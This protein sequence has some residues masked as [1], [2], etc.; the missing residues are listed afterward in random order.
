[1]WRSDLQA[2]VP[3][4]AELQGKFCQTSHYFFM[5]SNYILCTQEHRKVLFWDTCFIDSVYR[6]GCNE[7]KCK[8]TRIT[9]FFRPTKKYD[10]PDQIILCRGLSSKFI[11]VDD[12]T[13]ETE[14]L[15]ERA[16]CFLYYVVSAHYKNGNMVPRTIHHANCEGHCL[17]SESRLRPSRNCSECESLLHNPRFKKLLKDAQ[18]PARLRP[19]CALPDQYYSWKQMQV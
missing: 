4:L 16:N 14:L 1:M 10:S 12:I 6:Q 18:D 2:T 8:C 3:N 9:R 5:N 15:G 17:N 13:C 11:T 19:S 7:I